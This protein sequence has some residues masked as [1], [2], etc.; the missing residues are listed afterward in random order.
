[1]N[2]T[3][4]AIAEIAAEP[5][6]IKATFFY[7]AF[8]VTIFI[9]AILLAAQVFAKPAPQETADA[10]GQR[11]DQPIELGNV[12]WSRDLDAAVSNSKKQNKPIALLFQEVPG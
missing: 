3:P 11:V 4:N 7:V 9:L 2:R 8:C 12:R 6:V 1:M 10:D 5:S